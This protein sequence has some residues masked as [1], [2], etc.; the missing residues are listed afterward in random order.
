MRK[1]RR[2]GTVGEPARRVARGRLN[3]LGGRRNEKSCPKARFLVSE[4]PDGQSRHR[5]ERS[6]D[7]NN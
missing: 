2:T 7:R 3:A 5:A 6:G 1:D 4:I